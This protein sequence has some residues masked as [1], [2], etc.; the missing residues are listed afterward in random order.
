M[1]PKPRS[2]APRS[3]AELLL[4]VQLEQA[5]I[6]FVRE[7]YFAAPRKW[8]ADFMVAATWEQ[9]IPPAYLIEVEGGIW[10]K[11]RHVRGKG[12]LD[13]CIKYNMA[14]ELGYTVLR[15]PTELVEDGSALEQIRRILSLEERAA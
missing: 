9:R 12:Y 2:A 14:A 5:G 10:S 6:P 3:E 13:D 4:S 1:T 8:R 11:G 15:F 7:F